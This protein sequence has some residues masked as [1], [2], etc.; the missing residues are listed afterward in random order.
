MDYRSAAAKKAYA[1]EFAISNVEKIP[2]EELE[3][4]RAALAVIIWGCNDL[5]PESIAAQMRDAASAET[6]RRAAASAEITRR[7]AASAETTRQG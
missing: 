5:H 6:T 7:A 3:E 4:F 1:W 2:D